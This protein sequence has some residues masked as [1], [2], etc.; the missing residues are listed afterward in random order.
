MRSFCCVFF[1]VGLSFRFPYRPRGL[2]QGHIRGDLHWHHS[3]AGGFRYVMLA[4]PFLA[5]MLYIFAVTFCRDN[6]RA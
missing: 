4:M 2:T 3:W 5:I 1:W 6:Q